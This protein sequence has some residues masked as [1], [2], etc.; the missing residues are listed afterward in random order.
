MGG[1]VSG[2]DA[3]EHSPLELVVR[4]EGE[5]RQSFV[6]R[7]GTTQRGKEPCKRRR[8]RDDADAPIT[9]PAGA[10]IGDHVLPCQELDRAGHSI[11]Q[12]GL[13]LMQAERHARA[14]VDMAL[15]GVEADKEAE[16]VV[17]GDLMHQVAVMVCRASPRTV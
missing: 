7:A 11:D 12:V 14:S 3:V 1:A 4:L 16:V 15:C 6:S 9:R 8:V 5:R 10:V 17:E 13:V 2:Q